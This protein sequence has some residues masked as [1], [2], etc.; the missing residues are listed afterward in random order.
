MRHAGNFT[1][2]LAV[3]LCLMA[4]LALSSFTA[5]AD[6]IADFYRGKQLQIV[7]GF[8]V[9]GGYDAYGRLLARFMPKHI[10]GNPIGVSQNM[11]GA[12]SRKATNWMYSAAPKDGT[13]LAVTS[14]ST[15]LDQALGRD[16]I[17]FD[18]AKFNWI[19]NPIIDNQV[20]MSQD[21][22]GIATMDDLIK[23][24]EVVCGGTGATTNPV[25]FPKIMNQLIGTN[26]RVVQ[27]YP[28]AGPI[29]LAME[30]GE[31][32]C[33]GGHS[34]SAAKATL[35]Q[36]LRDRKINIVV[37]WGPSKDPEIS[38]YA[39]R[40]I[41]LITEYAHND[42]DREVLKLID[43]NMSIGRPLFASPD[44]PPARTA[45][46][47]RAFDDTMK[48]SEFLSEAKRLNMDIRPLPGT[49]LQQLVTEV[50]RA[51]PQVIERAKALTQ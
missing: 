43:S 5:R 9:G 8:E 48:D 14:Q 2:R 41:P 39:R 22:S 37:Q 34:W 16:G 15:P 40:D 17:A 51:S 44:I 4:T 19:G 12:G 46:L 26:I 1:K 42:I 23:K 27:G 25:I 45:A 28:G 3:S 47:R 13:I 31:V 18:A 49:D 11:L 32:S 6:E 7:V 30:R 50:V 38:E 29:M 35:S 10:P 36:Q 21:N 24:K 33:I 20:F